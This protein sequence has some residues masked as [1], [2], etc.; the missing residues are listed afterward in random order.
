MSAFELFL[1]HYS[2]NGNATNTGI[3]TPPFV[4]HMGAP[5]TPMQVVT[6]ALR[7]IPMCIS[8]SASNDTSEWVSAF[9]E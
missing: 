5:M 8:R 2:S 3:H 9:Q 6:H 1:I 4:G 7:F